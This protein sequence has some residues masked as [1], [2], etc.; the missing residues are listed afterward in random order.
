MSE[1]RLLNVT[2][3]TLFPGMETSAKAVTEYY[4]R[5][6]SELMTISN[7]NDT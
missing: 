7:N 6:Q 2:R 1:L 3:E 5:N 4:A